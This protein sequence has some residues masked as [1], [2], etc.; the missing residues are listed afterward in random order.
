METYVLGCCGTYTKKQ[1]Q[2]SA[3]STLV[4]GTW[5]LTNP[6]T[7]HSHREMETGN[8]NMRSEREINDLQGCFIP[9]FVLGGDCPVHV[10]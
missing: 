8:W 3:A 10:L 6:S 2:D 1:I 4:L 7:E 5:F 9:R